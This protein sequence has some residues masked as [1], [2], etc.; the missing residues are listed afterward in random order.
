MS[1]S[2]PLDIRNL[3][4]SYDD[5]PTFSDLNL[6]IRS[7][8]LLALLGPSGCG[9]SSLLRS[10]AGFITPQSGTINIGS[11]QVTGNGCALVAPQQR[12]VGMVFQDYALF[13]GMSVNQNIGFGIA[14]EPKAKER[15]QT[16]LNLF[17]LSEL[18]N[19]RPGE[20]SGGQQQRVAL[21]RALAPKPQFLLLDEPFAN[22][23][24]SLRARVGHEVRSALA[25]ENT[26]AL[27]VTHD[28]EE[29]LGLADR[30]AVLA[31]PSPEAVPT[32]I[33]IGTPQEIYNQPT[34]RMVAKLSG[35]CTLLNVECQND[36]VDTAIGNVA[37]TTTHNG[38]GTVVIRPEHVHLED[39]ETNA[40][41]LEV[42]YRG[43]QTECYIET[44]LGSLHLFVDSQHA[45]SP[46]SSCRVSIVGPCCVIPD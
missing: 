26:A 36:I 27:L 45:P 44:A 6:D 43:A 28:R 21:A 4:H 42:A 18:G 14:G 2:L 19:R 38:R 12:S 31:A 37:L 9:K 13:P 30:V 22:L 8:E 40:K 20:L 1:E 46:K 5:T 35:P 34:S 16:L 29:A 39:G 23:D 11:R 7:G 25:Q 10:I 15:I 41:V 33:Q 17:D 3:S 32:I 24:A